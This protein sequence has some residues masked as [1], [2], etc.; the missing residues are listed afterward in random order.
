MNVNLELN[1]W[2]KEVGW[3]EEEINFQSK[4]YESILKVFERQGHSGFSAEYLN[5]LIYRAFIIEEGTQFVDELN[6]SKDEMQ[7]YITKNF[8]ELKNKMDEIFNPAK[9]ENWSLLHKIL[10]GD[11]LTPLTGN[12]EEWTDISRMMW[13]REGV[14]QYQ[15]KRCS[16]VFKDVFEK[17][18][19]EIAYYLKE[20]AFSDNGGATWWTKGGQP[21]N[22]IKFPFEI[23][24]TKLIYTYEPWE[25]SPRYYILTDDETINKVRELYEKRKEDEHEIFRTDD[26]LFNNYCGVKFIP[27]CDSRIISIVCDKEGVKNI[28]TGENKSCLLTEGTAKTFKI[29]KL[30]W[31]LEGRDFYY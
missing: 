19:I 9:P 16:S 4:A 8:Y 15:N 14:R 7:D 3:S 21:Y 12:P 20:K 28:V 24:Q 23:P 18:N 5:S 1:Y 11:P 17:D 13:V 31:R 6:S 22:Q 26:I 10:K 25:D 30:V 29:D 27:E 2:G